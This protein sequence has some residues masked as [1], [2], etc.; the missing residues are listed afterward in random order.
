[1]AHFTIAR[2]EDKPAFPVLNPL[3]LSELLRKAM[4]EENLDL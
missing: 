3:E 2:Q 1:M 4:Q